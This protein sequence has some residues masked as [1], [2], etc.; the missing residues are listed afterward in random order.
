MAKEV[1]IIFFVGFHPSTSHNTPYLRDTSLLFN[2]T[3]MFDDGEYIELKDIDDD[4]FNLPRSHVLNSPSNHNVETDSE[5]LEYTEA[6]DS[7]MAHLIADG[8]VPTTDD[9]LLPS[10]TVRVLIIGSLWNIFLAVANGIFSF[11]TTAFQ[12][13]AIFATLLSYPMGIFL[14]K[15]LPKRKF[16]IFGWNWDLNDGEF[17]VKEHVLI[18]IIA[19]GMRL[20]HYRITK[21]SCNTYYLL[22]GSGIAYGLDNVVTQRMKMF[23]GNTSISFFEALLWVLSS[24]FIGFG[25]A[26]IMRRFLIKPAA[27]LWPKCLSDVA[28]FVGFHEKGTDSNQT[29]R[30]TMFWWGMFGMFLY[31]WFPLY[32]TPVLQSISVL[33]LI[34]SS[35]KLRFLA[36]GWPIPTGYG[37]VG[38]GSLTVSA[39]RRLLSSLIG[40]RSER[41]A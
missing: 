25:M 18:Y 24:Q 7:K 11:R 41:I 23:M 14:S 5:D 36:S 8:L 33:C 21:H 4:P 10:F 2:T 30:F 40:L 19:S 26:G 32:I 29:S 31:S 37:G 17:S 6:V 27:M 9:P 22:G 28:L 35:S 3:R 15:V 12:V 20:S 16:K 34:T 1:K 38:L 13:P 39:K